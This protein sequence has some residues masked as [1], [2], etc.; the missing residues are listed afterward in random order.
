MSKRDYLWAAVVL[1][2]VSIFCLCFLLKNR[3][4]FENK[5]LTT[6]VQDRLTGKVRWVNQPRL[7]S[8]GEIS[9]EEKAFQALRKELDL[10]Q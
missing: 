2:S 1:F 6:V 7:S 3:F 5:L 8:G 4:S 10:E 9:E